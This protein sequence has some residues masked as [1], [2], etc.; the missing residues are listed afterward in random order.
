MDSD[1]DFQR[2]LAIQRQLINE[3][4]QKKQKEAAALAQQAILLSQRGGSAAAAASA[5]A[6]PPSGD[7][8]EKVRQQQVMIEMEKQ[9]TVSTS[10]LSLQHDTRSGWLLLC[11]KPFS[12]HLKV[13]INT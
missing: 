1:P 3:E 6:P 10:S 5:P 2:K 13:L 4:E 9:Q 11:L 12:S 7:L 8:M